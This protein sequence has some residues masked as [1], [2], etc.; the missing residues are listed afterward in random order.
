M[1]QNRDNVSYSQKVKKVKLS[2]CENE[3]SPG[4]LYNESNNSR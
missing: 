4:S 2:L 3:S 1:R